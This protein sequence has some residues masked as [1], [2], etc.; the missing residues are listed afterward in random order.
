MMFIGRRKTQCS[1]VHSQLS[2]YLDKRLGTEERD[3]VERHINSCQAC[4]EELKSMQMTVHLLHDMP[5]VN[6]P[7]SFAI[8]EAEVSRKAERK[9]WFS[10]WLLPTPVPATY[11]VRAVSTSIFD[12][13]RLRWL[14]PATVVV[15]FILVLLLVLDFT[16]GRWKHSRIA[17]WSDECPGDEGMIGGR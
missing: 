15:T 6:V 12:P 4:A 5:L 7:R 16:H 1:R 2:E 14:R 8:R 11:G 9:R 17:S 13:W 10:G 3:A